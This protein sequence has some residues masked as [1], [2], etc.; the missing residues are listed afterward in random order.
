METKICSACQKP[1]P[2]SEFGKNRQT[3]DGLMYYCRPCASAKQRQ[4]RKTNPESTSASK[5][6]Y[7][8]KLRG[9]NDAARNDAAHTGVK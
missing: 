3:P 1:K 9:R 6:K 8:A 4:F 2:K 7:L 5:A